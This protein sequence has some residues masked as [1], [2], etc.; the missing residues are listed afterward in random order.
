[1]ILYMMPDHSLRLAS[2]ASQDGPALHQMRSIEVHPEPP[3]AL[4]KLRSLRSEG[5]RYI[6]LL[7]GRSILYLWD[8]HHARSRIEI[9]S[10]ALAQR[11]SCAAKRRSYRVLR[12]TQTRE[13]LP[14]DDWRRKKKSCAKLT[15]FGKPRGS[16]T[17]EQIRLSADTTRRQ[18]V[19]PLY[20]Q[21]PQAAGNGLEA[22]ERNLFA[23]GVHKRCEIV[24]GDMRSMPFSCASFCVVV[25][26]FSVCNGPHREGRDQAIRE[27]ARVLRPGGRLAV[28]DLA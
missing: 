23:E 14:C 4:R 22:A 16:D 12:D 2:P 17:Q 3:P 8:S 19:L 26:F 13:T 1:M 27:I 11:S 5:T 6:D 24:T 7:H 10:C 21:L 15:C 25:S 9:S 18:G 28:V 20:E